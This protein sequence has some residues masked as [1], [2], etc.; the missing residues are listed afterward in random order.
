M[1]GSRALL[2]WNV[3]GAKVKGR[4]EILQVKLAMHN[5]D[6]ICL[7]E[8][9]LQEATKYHLPGF[10]LFRVSLK[11]AW[12]SLIGVRHGIPHHTK[13][14]ISPP[15][16]KI[17]W[18]AVEVSLAGS[19]MVVVCVYIPPRAHKIGD[20]DLGAM[21][22]ALPAGP[23][24]FCGDFN[25]HHE[26]WNLGAND[27]RGDLVERWFGDKGY[28]LRANDATFLGKD[29]TTVVDLAWIDPTVA[30]LFELATDADT[31]GSDHF[32]SFLRYAG[33]APERRRP[34]KKLTDYDA[35]RKEMARLDPGG[36]WKGLE[37]ELETFNKHLKEAAIAST[38]TIETPEGRALPI[39]TDL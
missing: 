10:N 4:S 28:V 20:E 30:H 36:P 19:T 18:V 32:P 23:R 34:A 13:C 37:Q 24:I 11:P 16:S 9:K 22:A 8:T 27:P 25:G 38:R 6:V 33:N 2:F 14:R 39:W 15:T 7:N 29:R 3:K 12:G 17:E 21:L 35:F 5:V 26:S 31:W 1:E